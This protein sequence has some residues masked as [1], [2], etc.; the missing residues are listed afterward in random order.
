MASQPGAA[1]APTRP[2]VRSKSA[3][4]YWGIA[5]RAALWEDINSDQYATGRQVLVQSPSAMPCH[6]LNDRAPPRCKSKGRGCA[7]ARTSA[8]SRPTK[9]QCCTT[10]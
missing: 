6:D 2:A 8:A 3:Q 7:I 1:A 5:G 4:Q 9:L 10:R